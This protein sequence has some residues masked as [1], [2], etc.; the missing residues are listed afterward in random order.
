[1]AGPATWDGPPRCHLARARM[2]PGRAIKCPSEAD[3]PSGDRFGPRREAPPR[4]R[5]ASRRR[6]KPA[7]GRDM[8]DDVRSRL[9]GLLAERIVVLDGAMGTA[10]QGRGL[11]EE[12]FR[13]ERF[14]GHP[15]R[16]QGRQRPAEPHPAGRGGRTSIAATWRP[17]RTSSRRTRSRRRRCRRPTTG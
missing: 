4:S 9:D 17:A 5:E 11:T 12:D 10:I 15:T 2:R 7:G 16:P 1:M 6:W 14:A 8:T 13:G 3:I